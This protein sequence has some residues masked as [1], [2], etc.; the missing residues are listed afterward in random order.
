MNYKL[1]FTFHHNLGEDRKDIYEA[2]IISKMFVMCDGFSDFDV[3]KNVSNLS[4]SVS[5]GI[6][7][8]FYTAL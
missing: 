8:D 3:N 4:L 7:G 5:G 1:K 6:T 2:L